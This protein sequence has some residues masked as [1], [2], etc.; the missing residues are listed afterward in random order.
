MGEAFNYAEAFKSLDLNAVVKD[1]HALMTD[2]QDWWPADWGH[3]GGLMIRM[4]WHSAGTYRISDG[5]GGAG[6]GNQ[7][8][9]PLNS[10]PD[11]GNLD[12]ARRLLWPIKQKYGR[13]LSWADLMILAGNIALESMGFKTFGFAG[14]RE[15][16]WEPEEDIYWGSENTWLGDKRYSGDRQ[17]ENPLAAVQMGLIYVNPEGPNGNPDPVASGRDVR[18]TFARMAMNDEE[19]VAL[20]AGGHTFGKAH[21]AGDPKLVGPEPEGAAIEEQGL[22]WK[23]SFGTGKGV[24]TTTSGIEGAWKP[25]PT[26][27]DNG[28]F[29]MLF[30]Y[31]WELT[32]S[33]AGAHQWVAKNVKPEHMIAD[34]HDPSKKHPPMMT[35]ADLSLRFD[36]AYEKISRRFHQNP[37]A[38]ADAFAR[39][40]FKLTHRDMGPVARYLGPLVPKEVL[41]WQDPIPAVDHKLI[42]EQDIAALKAK[43]L[44][45]GL[46]IAQLVTTAWASAATFRGSDKRG[47]ANGARIRLA[48]QKDWEVNQPTELAKVLAKLEAIQKDFNGAQSGG[49]KIS[50]ADLIVLGGCA[51]V[52]AAAKKAGV[53]VKVPFSPGRMDATQAQTDV[54]SFAVLE[55]MA[56]G[57]RN[58]VRKGL[59]G[60]AGRAAGGQGE[61]DDADR[62]RDDGAGRWHA[63][64]E[65]ERR[66]GQ[67]RRL[68]QAPRDA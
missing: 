13:K 41:I 21:G 65:C 61:P 58:H 63:C 37:K 3:Y 28:Y 48:P 33:P 66:A 17:L 7:R 24:H 59:E 6:T 15:D 11:N 31:E 14:G 36:P 9:A 26:R 57:F 22:G 53:E 19:T 4:A 68:H 49:K 1:L 35:T 39:A 34:A 60:S 23:N 40:W 43:I 16:I 46:S 20:V 42:D 8:F 64:P 47:G 2:S 67:A 55:P 29:D 52:E 10:W 50:L 51:A 62:S 18:E 27:W 25:N 38:F 56:D 44:A 45:S 54:A 12:K 5:R 32:K 30:G